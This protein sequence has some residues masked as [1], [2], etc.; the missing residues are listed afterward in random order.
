M[1]GLAGQG[2]DF[3]TA[4]AQNVYGDTA[5]A[6]CRTGDEHGAGL[7]SLTVMLEPVHG[8]GSRKSRR[9]DRHRRA[10]IQRL[11]DLHEHVGI[12]ACGLGVAAVTRLAQASTQCDHFIAR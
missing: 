7:R 4:C 11:R 6:A 9:T 12:D 3:V 5:Y 2:C 1:V 10:R 8:Q